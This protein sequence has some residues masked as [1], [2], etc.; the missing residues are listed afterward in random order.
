[1][2]I[3]EGG[4]YGEDITLEDVPATLGQSLQATAETVFRESP[5]FALARSFDIELAGGDI[6]SKQEAEEKARQANVQLTIQDEG[7]STGAL[8]LLIE[9]KQKEARTKDVLARGP[10]GFGAGAAKLGVGLASSLFDP[11]N[12]ASAFMPVYGAAGIAARTGYRAKAVQGAVEGTVGAAVVEP[13]S[14]AALQHQQMDYDAQDAA[15]N[16]AFGA[17][18]GSTVQVAGK[19]F[20]DLVSVRE[21]RRQEIAA[22]WVERKKAEYDTEL[23]D[24]AAEKLA[25]KRLDDDTQFVLEERMMDAS[26]ET[27]QAIMDTLIRQAVTGRNFNATHILNADTRAFVG[28]VNARIQEIRNGV[29]E[30]LESVV[31]Q[32]GRSI[33]DDLASP[34]EIKGLKADIKGL[35]QKIDNL[36][37]ADN[38]INYREQARANLPKGASK[39]KVRAE[40]SRL[41][42]A[43]LKATNDAIDALQS[44]VLK[45]RESREARS[46]F[47]ALRSRIKNDREGV[48][49]AVA[50]LVEQRTRLF[51]QAERNKL[52]LGQKVYQEVS[53]PQSRLGDSATSVKAE[54]KYMEQEKSSTVEQAQAEAEA[55]VEMMYDRYE[56]SGDD[57]TAFDE[58]LQ[59]SEDYLKDMESRNAA[60]KEAAMCVMR[61]G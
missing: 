50:D 35:N 29:A 22:E 26:P 52:E 37:S 46:S 9:G 7:I 23:A 56:N 61:Q 59:S 14:Y 60:I 2:P 13:F 32:L 1:M 58:D 15:L 16:V 20:G 47:D 11:I 40:A 43:E 8:E 4:V 17:L 41:Q 42:E 49:D 6:L 3:Y 55:S 25:R 10:Q 44:K 18:F 45:G 36:Y 27:R 28:P 39:K 54:S 24:R 57:L 30:D 51:V 38:W 48:V 19:A 53:K 33:Y 34:K 31:E 5:T 21:R 12:V